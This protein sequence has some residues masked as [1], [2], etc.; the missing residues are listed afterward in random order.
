MAR[1]ARDFA[2]LWLLDGAAAHDSFHLAE[3]RGSPDVE[4]GVECARTGFGRERHRT[5]CVVRPQASMDIQRNEGE[6]DLVLAGE[7][8]VYWAGKL[9]CTTVVIM[10]WFCLP[11]M[12][13][14]LVAN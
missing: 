12:R 6:H 3:L 13:C 1:A 14:P 9:K 2:W 7:E 10:C 8:E 11:F 5:G 4:K